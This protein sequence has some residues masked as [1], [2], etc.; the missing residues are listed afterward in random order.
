MVLDTDVHAG[1][2]TSE[3][4]YSDPNVLFIDIHQ[5]PYTL[6]P[7]VGFINEIGEGEGKG[8]NVNIPLPPGSSDNAYKIALDEIFTPLALEYKPDMIVRNGGSDPH[9][10]DILASMKLN[11]KGFKMIG[12]KVRQISAQVTNRKAID[13]PGSGYNPKVLPYVW[14]SLIAGLAGTELELEEPIPY[15]EKV[16]ENS[17]RKASEVIKKVKTALKPYWKIDE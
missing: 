6:Y 2:G 4:F 16:Y 10:A 9:F 8:F 13:L 14:V 11:L 1:D 12:D 5:D 15:T 3:I 7:G 17:F